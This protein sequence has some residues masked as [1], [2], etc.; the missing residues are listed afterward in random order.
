MTTLETPQPSVPVVD[1]QAGAIAVLAEGLNVVTGSS[2]LLRRGSIYIGLLTLALAGPGVLA[3]I[4]VLSGAGSDDLVAL[5]EAPGAGNDLGVTVILL[6]AAGIALI[7]VSIEG[8]AIGAMLIGGRVLGRPVTLRLALERSRR[9][10][11]RL[12]RAAILVGIVELIA[13]VVWR[14]VTNAPRLPGDVP[15]F[16]IEPLVGAIVAVPFIFASVAIVIA[17]DGARAALRRSARIARGHVRLTFALAAFALL[18]G[19]LESFALGSGLDLILRLT[20]LLQLD[21]TTGGASLALAILLALLVVTATGSLVFTVAALVSAPQIVAWDRLGLPLTGLP[22]VDAPATDATAAAVDD[23]SADLMPAMARP[24]DELAPTAEPV[25]GV[26]M[27][28]AP[29][30]AD[31]VLGAVAQPVAIGEL[32]PVPVTASGWGQPVVAQ[33]L[34]AWAAAAETPPRF[35]WVT[36]P[37]RLTVIGLWLIAAALLLGGAPA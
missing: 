16:N 36:L 31:I 18:S 25:A 6:V 20:E 35:R 22:P 21:I 30:P 15:N 17:D 19:F 1:R 33:P 29:V 2:K 13:S 28:T 12:V 10:F 32:Q 11:W 14:A 24:F 9:V 27:V 26:P 23:P 3:G 8:G 34:S 37:M 4:W 5:F 7:A